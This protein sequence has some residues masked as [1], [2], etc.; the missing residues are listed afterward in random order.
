MTNWEKK[1]I[2]ALVAGPIAFSLF[3]EKQR[4]KKHVDQ[5]LKKIWPYRRTL[6]P[7]KEI[8]AIKKLMSTKI[9]INNA[10][11]DKEERF[12]SIPF[13]LELKINVPDSII[14]G[15]YNA[16][17][18]VMNPDY[19]D[20]KKKK[21]K[22]ADTLIKSKLKA[23][24]III[25]R[26]GSDELFD[27]SIVKL[28]PRNKYNESQT[29]KDVLLSKVSTIIDAESKLF[30][31]I[32]I[33]IE[34]RKAKNEAIQFWKSF[35]KEML[36]SLENT[37]NIKGYHGQ[38]VGIEIEYEGVYMKKI[39]SELIK[40][41]AISFSSGIDGL[42]PETPGDQRHYQDSHRLRENRLRISGH[43]GLNALHF[44]LEEMNKSCSLARNSGIHFHIDMYDVTKRSGI[45]GSARRMSP[46][47]K[48]RLIKMIREVFRSSI[49][50]RVTL[51][52]DAINLIKDLIG[53]TG[54]HEGHDIRVLYE[55][56]TFEVRSIKK[57]LNYSKM[58]ISI[59]ASIH[60]VNEFSK[61]CNWVIDHQS[62]EISEDWDDLI[63]RYLDDNKFLDIDY[64]KTLKEI[65][66]EYKEKAI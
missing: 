5:Y 52:D 14:Q 42:F 62:Q 26:N 24:M 33:R 39:K 34:K 27:T 28:G 53:I 55:Y 56:D 29:I 66:A 61:M 30:L 2:E 40:R 58:V 9:E 21:K 59:L 4:N 50:N 18:T 37:R 63:K 38:N 17:Y 48:K 35:L 51:G 41:G 1:C 32:N 60:F 12:K 47:I 45:K 11:Q 13:E 7:I 36:S 57:T 16:I 6:A 3:R 23:V 10:S 64:L 31:S 22:E 43:K 49:Y 15:L 54:Y 65:K 46:G 44:L 19:F 8:N 20:S 25:I